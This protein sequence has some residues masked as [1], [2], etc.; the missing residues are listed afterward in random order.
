MKKPRVEERALCWM[1]ELD[2]SAGRVTLP[3]YPE[4][5]RPKPLGGRRLG[6][7]SVQR[8]NQ[9]AAELL[10]GMA[11]W[12]EPGAADRQGGESDEGRMYLEV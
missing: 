11:I 12:A 5:E 9:N 2:L 7:S 8:A 3:E 1:E 4:K 10:Y 6:T